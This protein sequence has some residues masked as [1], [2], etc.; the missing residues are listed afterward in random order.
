MIV[1]TPVDNKKNNEY[2]YQHSPIINSRASDIRDIKSRESSIE[3]PN[4]NNYPNHPIP[5]KIQQNEYMN[6]Q[7]DPVSKTNQITIKG[8]NSKNNQPSFDVHTR[9]APQYSQYNQYYNPQ[10]TSSNQRKNTSKSNHSS[11]NRAEQSNPKM[12]QS[13]H[14]AQIV[15]FGLSNQNNR[16]RL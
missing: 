8:G 4:H 16:G 7:Y 12:R 6:E 1:S 5:H 10:Y 14:I 9:H 13:N 11:L 15:N 3:H 2:Y